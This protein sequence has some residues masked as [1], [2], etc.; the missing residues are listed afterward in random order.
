MKSKY[1]IDAPQVEKKFNVSRGRDKEKY[2][3]TYIEP[4]VA[5]MVKNTYRKQNIIKIQWFLWYL[6]YLLPLLV[7]VTSVPIIC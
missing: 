4:C 5:T 2:C 1:R 6:L 3:F 7:P